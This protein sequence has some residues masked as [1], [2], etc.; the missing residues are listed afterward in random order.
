MLALTLS[1]GGAMLLCL[2]GVQHLRRFRALR[3]AIIMHAIIPYDIHVPFAYVFVFLELTLGATLAAVLLGGASTTGI[4]SLA[5]IA[6]GTMYCGFAIYA[7]LLVRAGSKDP[8]GCFSSAQPANFGTVLRGL[9]IA[10]SAFAAVGRNAGS[11][12]W[13]LQQRVGLAL[14]ASLVVALAVLLP[15]MRFKRQA[16]ELR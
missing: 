1:L 13:S 6:T 4:G 12:Q 8:C 16:L 11:N 5:L 15:Q 10:C 14:A 7:H 3:S 2:S 9:V